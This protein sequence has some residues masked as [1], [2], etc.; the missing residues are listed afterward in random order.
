[1]AT[2]IAVGVPGGHELD[3]LRALG[4]EP[5]DDAIAY[6]HRE[7][8]A[9]SLP[10]LA[11]HLVGSDFPSE[12]D[13]LLQVLSA[14]HEACG[15]TLDPR[16]R[17]PEGACSPGDLRVAQRIFEE[18]GLKILLILASYALPSAYAAQHGVRV[19]HSDHGSTGYFVRDLSRRLIETAQFVIDIF[20]DGGM[21][22][23]PG[24]SCGDQGNA[25]RTLLR[26][27][28]LHAVVRA[29]IEGHR[30]GRAW[31]AATFGKPV[32]QEDLAGTLMTFSWLT[33]DGLE[34]LHVGLAPH[35]AEAYF[36]VW[37]HVGSLM[38][39]QIIPDTP[40]DAEALTA[41][42]KER[43]VDAPIRDGSR[44]HHGIELTRALLDFMRKSL[45]IPLRWTRLPEAL[46]RFFLP[47][48]PQ[49]VPA[50]LG[51]RRTPVLLPLVRLFVFLEAKLAKYRLFQAINRLIYVEWN[52]R[53]PR[54]LTLLQFSRGMGRRVL[55]RAAQADRNATLVDAHRP[56]FDLRGWEQRWGLRQA[57][58]LT[59][60][61]RAVRQYVTGQPFRPRP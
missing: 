10:R 57:N 32:N 48:A 54:A 7:H 13:D 6:W 30:E 52:Q 1:M 8:G 56:P 38:G 4:D 58:P 49:D 22:I 3:A 34:K 29:L 16:R 20:A 31:D 21:R 50:S 44:N 37:K 17:G 24:T 55:R 60:G 2:G 12:I 47:A 36:K 28:L 39:V 27:R 59:R 15:A 5:A 41:L 26:V 18:H 11:E 61:A 53:D 43:Q 9:K 45:P 33:L 51:I 19:L 40:A 42:I 35:E 23:E 46:M 25:I 14:G